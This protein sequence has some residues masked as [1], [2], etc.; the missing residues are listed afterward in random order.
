MVKG[1]KTLDAHQKLF[2]YVSSVFK[3]NVWG[4]N[5]HESLCPVLLIFQKLMSNNFW[6]RK[7]QIDLYY[8]M[9]LHEGEEGKNIFI[10]FVLYQMMMNYHDDA[11]LGASP[12]SD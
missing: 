11:V 1:Y 8:L 10:L 3:V 9:Q 5:I 4:A 12:Q 7:D 6:K 2:S